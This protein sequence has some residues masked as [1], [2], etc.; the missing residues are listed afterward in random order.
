MEE[1]A[2]SQIIWCLVVCLLVLSIFLM[3]AVTG[4]VSSEINVW[5]LKE[6]YEDIRLFYGR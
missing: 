1:K 3:I 6:N 5:Q 4:W 2:K